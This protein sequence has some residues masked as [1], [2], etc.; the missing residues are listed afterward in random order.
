MQNIGNDVNQ[1]KI[2]NL[3][4]I[5]GQDDI[6]GNSIMDFSKFRQEVNENFKFEFVSYDNLSNLEKTTYNTTHNFFELLGG[7][8]SNLKEIIISETM[9]KDDYTYRPSEGI[10]DPPTGRIIIKRTALSSKERFIAIFL[11][12][13]AHCSS[14]AP[15]STRIFESEL[16]KYLGLLGNKA[17][18]SLE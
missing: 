18:E 9:Q 6:L 11:H 5:Q 12:E 1:V 7:K 10:W 3:S 4:K 2:S 16:T 8:P 15:D 13:L 14:G 17:I